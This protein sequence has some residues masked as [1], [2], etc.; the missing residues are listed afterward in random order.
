MTGNHKGSRRAAEG[1]LWWWEGVWPCLREVAEEVAAGSIVFGHYVEQEWIR[2]EV[3]C[4]CRETWRRMVIACEGRKRVIPCG[5]E[6]FLRADRGSVHMAGRSAAQTC[7]KPDFCVHRLQRKISFLCGRFH[8]REG[9][10]KC[11]SSSH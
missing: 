2:V 4:L 8:C 11:I 3:Q 5:R 7:N 10:A 9:G 6:T 1:R